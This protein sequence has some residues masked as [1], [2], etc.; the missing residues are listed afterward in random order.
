MKTYSILSHIK[1]HYYLKL[2][3]PIKHR[4]FLRKLSQIPAYTQTHCNV[5][6]N[7]FHSACRRWY[8]YKNPQG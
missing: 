7:P 6:N 2:Q 3:I 1:I 5:R 4:D 8:L